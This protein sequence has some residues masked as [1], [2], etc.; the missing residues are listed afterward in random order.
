MDYTTQYLT[1]KFSLLLAFVISLFNLLSINLYSQTGGISHYW[2]LE[3]ETAPYKDFYTPLNIWAKD[4]PV[5]VLGIAGFAQDFSPEN[6]VYLDP[7]NGLQWQSFQSFSIEF[8]MKDSTISPIENEVIIGRDDSGS[9]D[10]SNVHWWVGVNSNSGYP[11]FTLFDNFRLGTSIVDSSSSI[12]DGAWH[13]VAEVRDNSQNKNFLYIDGEL[14]AEDTFDFLHNFNALNTPIQI[15]QLND[16]SINNDYHYDGILDELA[17]YSLALTPAAISRH[18]EDGLNGIGYRGKIVQLFL[19]NARQDSSKYL[20]DIFIQNDGL[21]SSRQLSNYLGNCKL[22]L[23]RDTAVT[24]ANVQ[25][26]SIGPRFD[27]DD[28][29]FSSGTDSG[30]NISIN[31]NFTNNGAG[32]PLRNLVKELICTVQL[33]LI[34]SAGND[35]L[36]NPDIRWIPENT[37]I[38]AGDSLH[39]PVYLNELESEPLSAETPSVIHLNYQLSQNYPNPFNPATKIEFVIQKAGNINL[40]IYNILGQK[41]KELASGFFE[42]GLHTVAFDAK[43]LSSGTY[44][45]RLQAENFI[46][47]KKMVL[48]K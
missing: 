25:I 37:I 18:Y 15:G 5:Q 7:D 33:S 14:A 38:T 28:Y 9:V 8:W 19:E 23:T 3:E 26:S 24:D 42:R 1:K 17:F 45:Y 35:S 41:I 46:Q 16:Y 12:A 30:G 34:D 48:V 29:A 39:V 11:E 40:S 22:K 36:A 20:F 31:I 32:A 47:A 2:M 21:S 6:E 13:H 27:N 43:D 10:G 44:I 4:A